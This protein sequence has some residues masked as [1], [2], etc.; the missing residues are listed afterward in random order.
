[1][2][3][4][5]AKIVTFGEI[6]MRLSP[7]QNQKMRQSNNLDFTFGGT[8]LNVAASLAVLEHDVAHVSAVPK[9][10]VGEAA[11]QFVKGF[12]VDTEYVFRNDHPSGQYILEEGIG[13]R[14]GQVSYNRLNASFAHIDPSDYNWDEIFKDAD[15]FHWTGITPGISENAL[16]TLKKALASARD[17]NILI[18][19]DPTFR[20]NLWKYG[21]DGYEILNELVPQCDILFGGVS[22]INSLLNGQFPET[23]EGFT[24]A[25]KALEEQM[26]NIKKVFGK[27]RTDYSASHHAI[28]G[29]GFNG[30][31]FSE[32]PIE[33]TNIVDRI[34]TGDAFAAGV[35]HGLTKGDDEYA[36]K[37][38]LAA[39]A[40][41]HTIPKDINLSKVNEIEEIVNGNHKGRLKR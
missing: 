11:L 28:Y 24:N 5:R 27:V 36:L 40:I 10:F 13:M 32:E 22:E 31:T 41:K 37:F 30:E 8:E 19:V 16:I 9:D 12:G 6:I 38:G 33:I 1:M 4:K 23:E 21:K 39:C 17:K 34:G 7:P 15:Y 20:S 25:C 35:I 2:T 26:P 18:S 14:S 3:K 29:Q